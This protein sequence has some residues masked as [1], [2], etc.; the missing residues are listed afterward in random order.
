MK[1][2]SVLISLW[3]V[4]GAALAQAL[5][6]L[7]FDAP[8]GFSGGGDEVAT[9]STP[10]RDV[11][12]HIYPFRRLGVGEFQ[13]RFRETLLREFVAPALRE[14]KPTVAPQIEAFNVEGAEAAVIGRFTD[15]QRTRSRLAMLA[16]GAVAVIDVT[17]TSGAALE[18]HAAAV[19]ELLDSVSVGQPKARAAPPPI[20]ATPEPAPA[21]AAAAPAAAAAK[22][23]AAP[24]APLPAFLPGMYVGNVRRL[25]PSFVGGK[26]SGGMWITG[27]QYF[28]LSGDGL[29]YRNYEQPRLPGGDASRFD[30]KRA[31]VND[32]A[33]TGTYEVI[34]GQLTL[35]LGNETIS[36]KLA[37]P[38][39][40]EIFGNY[41]KRAAAP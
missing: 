31:Q 17:A 7:N 37:G 23:Q 15:Q 6:P 27:P 9:F 3:L 40:F 8:P 21:V 20:L 33:N 13:A 26:E 39:R 2:L 29:A 10:E 12:I 30:W 28:L 38:G 35:R 19:K 25:I 22:P 34:G 14:A 24:A 18:R 32:A 4:A 5:P 11:V 41:F 1:K 36:A 16:S